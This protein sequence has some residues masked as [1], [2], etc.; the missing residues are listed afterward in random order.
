MSSSVFRV[1][2]RK[3]P[4]V[5]ESRTAGAGPGA[6][7]S[8][9]EMGRAWTFHTLALCSLWQSIQPLGA[10]FCLW[11]GAGPFHNR[12]VVPSK[13]HDATKTLSVSCTW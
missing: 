11:K 9:T 6:V 3:M 13:Q 10:S 8:G 4:K 12:A 2:T 1:G 5:Q 7:G